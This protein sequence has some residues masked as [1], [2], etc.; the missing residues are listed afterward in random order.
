MIENRTFQAYRNLAMTMF[1][2][3]LL[4]GCL[5]PDDD[6]ENASA[7]TGA[8]PS[9]NSAPL[10]AGFPAR[11]VKINEVYN[12]RPDA[13]DADGDALSFTIENKP[14]WANF[15]SSTGVISGTPTIADVGVHAMIVIAVTDGAATTELRPFAIDVSQSALGSVS[16]SWTAPTQNSDGSALIDLAGYNIY[17]GTTS[18]SYDQQI[19]IDNPSVTTFVVEELVADTYYFAATSFNQ[20]NVESAF[21]GEAIRTVD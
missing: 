10:I 5:G 8:E 7:S 13:S 18:G 1:V 6:D 21:S 17:Y 15:D 2:A 4:S 16:L 12:F 20:L 19:R 14:N 9:G 3:I 11:A